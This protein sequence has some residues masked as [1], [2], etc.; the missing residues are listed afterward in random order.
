MLYIEV[1]GLTNFK[2]VHDA[3]EQTKQALLDYCLNFYPQ[4]TVIIFFSIQN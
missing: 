3:Y 4:I 1:R 2:L